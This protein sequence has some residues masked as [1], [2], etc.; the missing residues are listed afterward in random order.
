MPKV[1]INV[2][3]T[4]ESLNH[5]FI[6][7]TLVLQSHN[8]LFTFDSRELLSYMLIKRFAPLDVNLLFI[9]ILRRKIVLDN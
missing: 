2:D 6:N 7:V 1:N 4:Q 5:V 3:S 9:N 8:F